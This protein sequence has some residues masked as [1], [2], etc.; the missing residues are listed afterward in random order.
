MSVSHKSTKPNKILGFPLS[1][2]QDVLINYLVPSI[3]GCALYIFLFATDIA[4]THRYFKDDESVWAW[5]T[6][7]IMYLPAFGSCLIIMYSAELRP[8]LKLCGKKNLIWYLC[9]LTLH[10]L[11]PVWALWR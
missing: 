1:A 5:T 8:E 2:K 7:G 4:L 6:Y 11:F 10:L 9:K 3:G